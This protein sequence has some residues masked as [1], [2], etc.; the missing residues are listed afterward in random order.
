LKVINL[1]GGP[2]TG[3]STTAAGL[4]FEMKNQG[5][6]CELAREYAK[7]V[8]WEG[9]NHLLENQIYIFAK[10][11]KRLLDLDEQVD[12]AVTDSPLI[13]SLVYRKAARWKEGQAFDQLVIEEFNRFD[14]VNIFLQRVKPFEQ[15]GRVQ[16]IEEAKALDLT[17]EG[18]LKYLREP[19]QVV[20]AN[21]LAPKKIL[22]ILGSFG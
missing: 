21:L 7:D 2:G 9:R 10:Q 17:I 8:V 16:T 12:Y 11:L 14:N 22:E 6:N 13:L 15:A 18:T 1:Y 4:F 19:Y 20:E 3:K 5:I